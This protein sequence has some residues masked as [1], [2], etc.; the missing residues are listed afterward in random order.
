MTLTLQENL[1][2]VAEIQIKEARMRDEKINYLISK[3]DLENIRDIR[4]Q[5]L[6]GG[7]K[8]RLILAMALV[9]DPELLLL[10]EPFS[11]LDLRSIKTLQDIIINLQ[12]ERTISI[13]ITDHQAADLLKVCDS[14]I[15]LAERKVIAKGLPLS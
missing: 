1:Q 15:V 5:D 6:S 10:D 11:A 14:A 3:F 7:Q 13:V 4:A 8:K 12:S 2:A 9:G